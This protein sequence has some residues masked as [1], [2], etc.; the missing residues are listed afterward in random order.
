MTVY[1]FEIDGDA[2]IIRI[3]DGMTELS[4]EAINQ[5]RDA[6]FAI[7]KEV[8]T[9]GSGSLSSIAARIGISLNSDGT[10]KGSALTAVG[11]VTL[12]IDNSEIGLNA[13]IAETKLALN[14][15]TSTLN[16]LITANSGLLA[17]LTAFANATDS[18]LNTHIAGGSL[19][20]D[21][22]PARHVG[23]H[24][25][26]NAVPSDPRDVSYIWAGL[27][28][29]DGDLRSAT[30][31]GAALD[32]INT[33]LTSH[34]NAVADAHVGT[35]ISLATDDFQEIPQTVDTVQK[36][37]DHLDDFEIITVADHRATDHSAGT[38]KIGRVTSCTLPDGY[39]QNVVP[40]T[41]VDTF[42]VRSPNITPV[43][44]IASG[45]DLVSFKPIDNSDFSFDS[46][47]S[48][49]RVGDIIRI[50]Y[51]SGFEA[52]FK[53]ESLRFSPGAEW[54]VRLNGV[55]LMDSADGYAS[56]RIDRPLYNR[57]TAGILA[58]AAANATPTGSFDNTL[59]SVIVAHPRGA[60]AL[61][62][63]F[64]ANQ[65][66]ASNYNLYLE[67]YPTGNPSDRVIVLPAIDVTGNL[68]V[69]PGRYTLDSV[70]HEVNKKFR[71]IGYNYRFIAFS[72]NGNFGIML[73][74]AINCASFSITSGTISGAAVVVGL[75]PN[76][77][78]GDAAA[79][80]FDALGFGSTHSN[81]ASPAFGASFIDA[82]IAQFPT[83]VIVPYK[84]RDYYADGQRR[85]TFAPTW[86]ATEDANGDG[87]WDGYISARTS[88]GLF[89]IE[90]TYTINL[91]LKPAGL[92]AGKTIVI[93]PTVAFTDSTYLDVDYGRF[94]IKSV[95]FPAVCPGETQ[96]TQITVINGLH[97][98]GAGF[99]FSSSPSLNVKLY[100]SEDSVSFNDEN[101]IASS[102]TATNYH[103]LHEVFINSAGNTFSHER[104]RLPVQNETGVLLRSDIW[105]VEYVSPKLRGYRDNTTTFNKYLRFYIL[106][107]NSTTGEYDGYI[108]QRSPTS[109]AILKVGPVTTGRKGVPTRFYDETYVDFI[110]LVFVE[111]AATLA[112]SNDVLSSAVPRYVDIEVFNS[113]QLNDDL[114]MLASVEVNWEPSTGQEIIQRVV[115]TREIGS[116]DEEDFTQGAIDFITAG[117]RALHDNGI[118]RGFGFDVISVDDREIFYKGGVALVNGRIVTTNAISVTI[119]EIAE[120]PN[121]TDS[122][123]WAVCVN[124]DGFLE[125]ILIT[126]TK[127]QFFA[128]ENTSATTY[129]VPSV[130]FAELVENRK[131]LVPIAIV[132]AAIASITINDA[133]VV[134]VRRFIDDGKGRELVYSPTDFVGTFH[135][136]VALK[137]WVNSYASSNSL[138]VKVRG[139]FNIS[140]TIDLT[141]FTSK[142]IL[143]GD[144]ASFTINANQG[145][146]VDTNITLKNIHFIYNLGAVPPTYVT[147]DM[148]N[149]A[150][151]CIYRGSGNLIQNVTIENCT[152]TSAVTTQ[153]P[154]FISFERQGTDIVDNLNIINNTFNDANTDPAEDQ[155]A[156]SIITLNSTGST[157]ALVINSKIDGNVCNNHQGIFITTLA[158]TSG[159]GTPDGPA[160]A[161]PG[162][163][164]V[165]VS[166]SNNSC[167]IIGIFTT[168][169]ESAYALDLRIRHVG[170]L[171]ILNN[172]VNAITTLWNTPITATVPGTR[173]IANPI[174][175]T[176][177]ATS[178]GSVNISENSTHWIHIACS[179]DVASN[180][181]NKTKITN[182]RLAAF[183]INWLEQWSGGSV[184]ASDNYAIGLYKQG[185]DV[186]DAFVSGNLITK[187]RFNAADYFYSTGIA[188]VD[189]MNATITNNT[190]KGLVVTTGVGISTPTTLN[191]MVS[192]TGNKIDREGTTIARYILLSTAGTPVGVCTDNVFDTFTTGSDD[193]TINGTGSGTPGALASSW[194]VTQ[195]KNQTELAL[196]N[197][198]AGQLVADG[199]SAGGLT[200]T[201][202]A[203][204]MNSVTSGMQILWDAGG[205]SFEWMIP[206][207]DFLPLGVLVTSVALNH[208]HSSIVPDTTNNLIFK[209]EDVT[210]AVTSATFNPGLTE[211]A[212]SLLSINK[213]NTARSGLYFSLTWTINDAADN[214]SA[215]ITD[216]TVTYRW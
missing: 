86:L 91:D 70:V 54:F 80:G 113:M 51:G 7:E 111:E 168:G 98:L 19:L 4:G 95:F 6:I 56:A 166:I 153:R 8:G 140:T 39:G 192:I 63:G 20:A 71:E 135:T 94:I 152:F 65:L 24:I 143:D 77:V 76:N 187:G 72:H 64:D 144:G 216:L 102:P 60:M 176:A 172:S 42:L 180:E 14:F 33:A 110:D 109:D 189:A 18:D 89:T 52:S 47:F 25:D 154:P 201:Q 197:G 73:A 35:A 136:A 195:N 179:D 69:T 119:P 29:K 107:W 50:N 161:S 9:G 61:G 215:F 200:Q 3:D 43:D 28:N 34:E 121:A 194:V 84:S 214:D 202:F 155:A 142:V 147:N 178:I 99:G 173:T 198:S 82:A 184:T 208:Q 141:G 156:I 209:V 68:G 59:S 116:I 185:T 125:P 159:T 21:G 85:D 23:S 26:L 37:A 127:Q 117:D 183:D 170:G 101:V 148:I 38:R 177:V 53:V 81:I 203:R 90:T 120:N 206:F 44:N 149:S 191:E 157:P 108:G 169:E 74:D 97:G 129:H 207:N 211:T 199:I 124:E 93:Q 212:A 137:K 106:S 128:I 181:Y 139:S 151:G 130:T 213:R 115:N 40:N 205:Q 160:I 132:T 103:R 112:A 83:K 48:Q 49:V 11:L 105:H 138:I 114:L 58:V 182:N 158:E 32:Q 190:I 22:S 210:S 55:N 79:T 30:T 174:V 122:I 66:D 150:N 16:T 2:D 165:N 1:P 12:P 62:N 17:A 145:I 15:S 163:A 133:D 134:D 45:D 96:Q 27:L 167:G 41:P 118:I 193:E 92:K 104:A 78:I 88:V 75:F 36:L 204:P 162:I 146:L 186:S 67:L 175:L 46:Q 31:V 10:L 188:M 13:G 126:P 131:D 171:D 5:A 57:D 196:I 123:D 100:F 87:Y 164:T